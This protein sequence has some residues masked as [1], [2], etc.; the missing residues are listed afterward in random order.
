MS[1]ETKT[2]DS[3]TCNEN[4]VLAGADHDEGLPGLR[5]RSVFGAFLC[6]P[7]FR[8][9]SHSLLFFFSHSSDLDQGSHTPDLKRGACVLP[10]VTS[11]ALDVWCSYLFQNQQKS[12]SRSQAPRSALKIENIVKING[13]KI[14]R[15][16][17]M[18]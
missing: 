18:Q 1:H 7:G 11:N 6:W 2:G 13:I 16:S 5:H 10:F 14:V 3:Q 17:D 8:P 4:R 15:F 12:Q 9:G